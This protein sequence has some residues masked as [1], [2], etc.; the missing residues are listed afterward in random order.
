MATAATDSWRDWLSDFSHSKLR[1]LARRLAAGARLGHHRSKTKGPGVEFQGHREYAP[2]DDLRRL[3]RRA[4]LRHGKYL[5]R[6]FQVETDQPLHLIV[7][8]SES[9][10]YADGPEQPSKLFL[11]TLLAASSALIARRT[12]DPVGLSLYPNAQNGSTKLEKVFLPPRAGSEPGERLLDALELASG[13]TSLGSTRNLKE[14]LTEAALRI[15]SGTTILW[16]S[17]F[18]DPLDGLESEIALLSEK[19]RTLIGIRIETSREGEFPF[20]GPMRFVDPETGREVETNADQAKE[21]YLSARA[22]HFAHL[23]QILLSCRATT[24]VARTSEEPLAPLELLGQ[25]L[26]GPLP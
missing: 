19:Q 23:E 26:R 4:L 1:Y 21:R 7:D 2:G 24:I 20:T 16:F 11:A 6:E 5:L 14:A 13:S 18:L 12:A 22:Q 15:P 9:M 8:L 10:R 25:H 3:D 17:D